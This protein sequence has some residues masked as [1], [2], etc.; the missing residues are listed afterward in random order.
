MADQAPYGTWRS[1]LTVGDVARVPRL[2]TVAAEDGG[3]VWWQEVHPQQGGRVTVMRGGPGVEAVKVLVADL[4]AIGFRDGAGPWLPVGRSAAVAAGDDG[5]RLFLLEPGEEPLPLTGDAEAGDGDAD[6]CSDLVRG[7][8]GDTLWCVRESHRRAAGVERSLVVVP[9]DGSLAVRT[10]LTTA[11]HLATPRPSPDGAWLAWR[12]WPQELMP[13]DGSELRVGRITAEGLTE[14]RTLLGGPVESVLQP[15]WASPRSQY[16]ISDRTR[17]WNLYQVELDGALRPLCPWAEEFGRPQCE[18][19]PST[20]GCLPDGRLA[21]LHGTEEWRLDVLDPSDGVVTPLALPY[22]AWQPPLHAGRAVIAG[23]G[24]TPASLPRV[25]AVELSS[26]RHSVLSR[27]VPEPPAEFLPLSRSTVFTARD[28]H[29]V[30]VVVHPPRHPHFQSS[31][32]E[33]VPYLLFLNDDPADQATGM[34]DLTI[35]FFTSR[36]LGVAEIHGR[37]SSGY[38]RSYREQIYGRWGTA[39][40]EDCAVAV[41]AL[42]ERWVADPARMVVRGTGAGGNTALA[43]LAGTDLCVAATVYAPI[44]AVGPAAPGAP[45]A[46]ADRL[47]VLACD[48]ALLRPSSWPAARIHRPVLMLHGLH[49]RT[50]PT[51]HTVLLRDRLQE[52]RVP[53][54]CLIFADE[55]HVFRRA[56]TITHALQAELSFYGQ[57]RGFHPQHTPH[58]RM[59]GLSNEEHP[60]SSDTSPRPEEVS[61]RG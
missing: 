32:R 12:Q 48:S 1:S 10:L 14:V 39:D 27:P 57:V 5:H 54:A 53:H 6:R 13:W 11:E 61:T 15:E 43:V 29:E 56:E 16:A 44:T 40:V 60:A 51:T 19:G 4:D 52:L 49:D 35:A 58:L 36:G 20:Y 38:G 42:T 24:G 3:A 59:H 17:W 18:G 8:D 25:V 7:P 33:R 47:R 26:G 21:V 45:P 46:L 23:V 41:R 31:S 55:G 37:G 2:R 50:V 9:L 30:H 28:G 34:L 22:T